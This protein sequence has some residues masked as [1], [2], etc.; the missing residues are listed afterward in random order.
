M[1]KSPIDSYEWPQTQETRLKCFCAFNEPSDACRRHLWTNL[2]SRE[3]GSVEL[4]PEARMFIISRETTFFENFVSQSKKTCAKNVF[5][6]SLANMLSLSDVLLEPSGS[7]CLRFFFKC[8]FF[9]KKS[10]KKQY[11]SRFL[12]FQNFR[13]CQEKMRF[14][15]KCWK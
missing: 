7:C 12:L 4:L 9:L 5:S 13:K 3:H 2:E 10:W 15:K 11:F 8:V 1:S 6:F 14:P